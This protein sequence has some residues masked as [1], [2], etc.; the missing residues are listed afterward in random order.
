MIVPQQAAVEQN[1][2]ESD[3]FKDI[4]HLCKAGWCTCFQGS[5]SRGA[6]CLLVAP[7]PS[8]A[9]AAALDLSW[10]FW[11]T[12]WVQ[13]SPG[14]S[15]EQDAGAAHSDQTFLLCWCWLKV[16][17]R[18]LGSCCPSTEELGPLLKQWQCWQPTGS[19]AQGYHHRQLQTQWQTHAGVITLVTTYRFSGSHLGFESKMPVLEH[20]AEVAQPFSD[21]DTGHVS[22]LESQ[23]C[24]L[25]PALSHALTS[26]SGHNQNHH[27]LRTCI[28]WHFTCCFAVTSNTD[29]KKK[30]MMK[31][32]NYIALLYFEISVQALLK[33]SKVVCKTVIA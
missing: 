9:S 8:S 19:T 5:R 20:T 17:I 6:M 18:C 14:E 12:S 4:F 27:T 13:D 30:I 22:T 2:L 26:S 32:S 3:F 21:P 7:C 11:L 1:C 24:H 23:T 33:Q 28:S 29:I 10:H 15:S 31:L 16:S 25:P